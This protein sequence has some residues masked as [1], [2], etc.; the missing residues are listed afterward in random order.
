MEDRIPTPLSFVFQIAPNPPHPTPGGLPAYPSPL[1]YPESPL[2][3]FDNPVTPTVPTATLHETP[4]DQL[5]GIPRYAKMGRGVHRQPP[6]ILVSKPF[7]PPC[8]RVG[9]LSGNSCQTTGPV[10]MNGFFSDEYPVIGG[11]GRPGRRGRVAPSAV[12]GVPP[13]LRLMRGWGTPPFQHNDYPTTM[14]AAEPMHNR[15]PEY[16]ENGKRG[17]ILSSAAARSS[18]GGHRCPAC[19]QDHRQTQHSLRSFSYPRVPG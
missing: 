18:T 12:G 8:M 4:A 3:I 5:P 7:R 17:I 14:S 9:G 11:T 2:L 10:C 1:L 13:P 15:F 19:T 16:R 6:H